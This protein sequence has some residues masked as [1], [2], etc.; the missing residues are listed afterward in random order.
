M[1]R[2]LDGSRL[3]DLI[4]RI[5][6]GVPGI[7]LRTTVL[8]GHPGETEEDF[9]ELLDFLRD[10]RFEHLGAF[11]YSPEEGTESADQDGPVPE[12]VARTRHHEVMA[13]QQSI[14][15]ARNRE[16]P[17]RVVESIVDGPA[18]GG[19]VHPGRTYGDAPDIDGA[20]LIRGRML[21]PGAI[22]PVRV[23]GAEG[24]DLQGEWVGPDGAFPGSL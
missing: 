17:G 10:V 9:E 12:D 20:I 2:G 14:A 3:R 16:M 8:V 7:V 23:T 1:R 13:L 6:K 21:A 22:G 15:F 11:V 19:G 5:R 24:Y 18:D 4:G